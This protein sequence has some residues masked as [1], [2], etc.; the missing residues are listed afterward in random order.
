MLATVLW[1]VAF[2]STGS[3]ATSDK[4]ELC[5]GQVPTIVD[6][7]P[8]A[9]GEGTE[10][11]DVVVT[12]GARGFRLLGGDDLL[13]IIGEP[14]Y[15]YPE[16]PP[17]YDTGAGSDHVDASKSTIPFVSIDLGRGPDE[18]IG[19]PGDEAVHADESFSGASDADVIT[20]AGGDD[21]VYSSGD[22]VV[23]LGAGPDLL[24]V[25]LAV[26]GGDFEGGGNA[27]YL[28]ARLAHSA[29]HAW[30]IDNRAGRITRD[31]DQLATFSGF[32]I[33][34][35]GDVRGTFRFVGSDDDEVFGI[36]VNRTWSPLKGG[37]EVRTKGGDDSVDVFGSAPSSRFDG[38]DGT[39]QLFRNA[40]QYTSVVLNLKSGLLRETWPKGQT[41]TSKANDF[42]N[43]LLQYPTARHTTIKGTSEA[44]WLKVSGLGQST[45]YGKA[46]DDELVGGHG[47]GLLIGGSGYDVARGQAGIDRCKAEIRL[48]CE[49]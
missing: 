6:G 43:A 32:S 40:R 2:Q 46:G 26:F 7:A 8:G 10:G 39:D 45:I 12:N 44:N 17:E 1:H 35:A 42:E 14:D 21:Q 13:C 18:M 9:P 16:N 23:D 3:V 27:D 47:E 33:F 41:T 34:Q 29:E 11:P 20:T 5:F 28:W 48:D 49:F 31:G 37:I 4:A 38:G 24:W 30:K 15:Y 22:D 36:H 19:G 25:N